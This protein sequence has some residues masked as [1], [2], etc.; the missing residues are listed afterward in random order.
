MLITRRKFFALGAG[1]IGGAVA[2]TTAYKWLG[3]KPQNVIIS[4]LNRRLTQLNVD[5]TSFGPFSIAYLDYRKEYRK[6]LS[7]MSIVSWP[8]QYLSPYAVLPQ[9]SPI[10]RLE[11]NIVSMYLMST[12]FFQNGANEKR[13]IQYLSF[14]DPYISVCRNP[15]LNQG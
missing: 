12:D 8:L 3:G 15:F 5:K 7:I 9:G 10:H 14:Y 11:D 6:Q 13:Q 4:I 1:I 2:V